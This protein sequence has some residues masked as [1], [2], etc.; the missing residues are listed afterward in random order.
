[1]P[2]KVEKVIRERIRSLRLEFGFSQLKAADSLMWDINRYARLENMDSG[3]R[4]LVTDLVSISGLFN[5]GLEYLI[6][7]SGA[8][9]VDKA[10]VLENIIAEQFE[11]IESMDLLLKQLKQEA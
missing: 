1:M 5:V 11:V 3:Q 2:Y 7:E 4:I 6:N 9:A 8:G 10:I